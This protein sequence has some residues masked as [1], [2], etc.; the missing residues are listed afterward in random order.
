MNLRFDFK[1][2]DGSLVYKKKY[3]LDI[4]KWRVA[5]R[6]FCSNQTKGLQFS[7]AGSQGQ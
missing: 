5:N 4:E 3:L 7:D 1:V 6:F 2:N